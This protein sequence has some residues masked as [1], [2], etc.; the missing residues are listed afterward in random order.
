MRRKRADGAV[1]LGLASDRKLKLTDTVGEWLPGE[2]P[3]AEDVAVAQALQHTAGL[4][5]RSRDTA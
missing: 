4:R 3:L 1:A 5:G 2:L